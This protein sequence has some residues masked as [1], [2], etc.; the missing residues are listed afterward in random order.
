MRKS[1][2][3]GQRTRKEM[4]NGRNSGEKSSAMKRE[5]NGLTSGLLIGILDI[6]EVR[7]GDINMMKR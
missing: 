4:R 6:E 5:R 7:I 1:A 3:S 2:K